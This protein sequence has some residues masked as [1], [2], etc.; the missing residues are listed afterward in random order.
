MMLSLTKVLFALGS[1]S[2]LLA[3]G[4]LVGAG[5]SQTAAEKQQ[6][7]TRVVFSRNQFCNW[8]DCSKGEI[9]IINLNGS[10]FKRLLSGNE[11]SEENP[12]WSPNK[13]RIAFMRAGD[14]WVMDANGRHQRRLPLPQNQGGAEPDWSP[15]GRT[16]V[17][18]ES[19]STGEGFCLWTVNV[20]TGQRRQLTTTNNVSDLSPAWS[21]D[22]TRIAFSRDQKIW[23]MRMRNHRLR[24]LTKARGYTPVWSPDGRRIAFARGDIWVMNADGTHAHRVGGPVDQFTWSADGKWFIFAGGNG[25]GGSLLAMHSNG[26]GR[27]VLRRD[28]GGPNGWHDNYPDG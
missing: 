18:R 15:N 9:A 4:S 20:Q 5:N 6:V 11:V 8:G 12:A 16:I 7:D 19:S 28:S 21:P 3:A 14:I 1:V 2:V 27:H 25:G 17:Y 10:G 23:T 24:Q 22:G 26:S 13:S